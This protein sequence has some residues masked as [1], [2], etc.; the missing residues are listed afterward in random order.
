MAVLELVGHDAGEELVAR[1]RSLDA[2]EAAWLE[3]L[4]CFVR[5]QE[6]AV[7]GFFTAAHW[8]SERCAMARA[9]AYEKLRVAC[10]LP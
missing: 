5:S 4:G 1:R 9:T 10:E 2:D 8:L 3:L 7:E 6:W